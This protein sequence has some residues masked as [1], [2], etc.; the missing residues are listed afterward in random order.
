MK[1]DVYSRFRQ[2]HKE[3]AEIRLKNESLIRNEIGLGRW[4]QI[5]KRLGFQKE[6]L[7]GHPV[8]D[9]ITREVVDP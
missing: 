7:F 9:S 4:S 6:D 2:E 3:L 5:M 8:T 1:S